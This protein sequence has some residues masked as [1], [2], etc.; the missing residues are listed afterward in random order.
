M[1]DYTTAGRSSHTPSSRASAETPPSSTVTKAKGEGQIIRE[2]FRSSLEQLAQVQTRLAQENSNHEMRADAIM[3]DLDG[4]R[5]GLREIQAE[6]RQNQGR[7]EASV[8]FLNDLIKQRETVADTRMAEMSAI[9][10]ERDRQ[11]DERMKLMAD[12]MQRRDI[13]ANVR[14]VD[15]MTTMQD[16]TL[17]V[18]AIVS[19]TAATQEQAAPRAPPN[20]Q[21]ADM[22]S[23]SAA[24]QAPYRTVAKSTAEQ[25]RPPK[26]APPAT[27]KRDPPK[28]TKMAKIV[29]PESRDAGT[30]PMSDLSSFDLYAR[31][32][33]TSGGSHSAADETR[34]TSYYT[35]NSSAAFP[36]PARTQTFKDFV[37]RPV[38][39]STQRKLTTKRN[40]DQDHDDAE[41]LPVVAEETPDNPRTSQR[42]ALAEALSTAMSKGLEPLLAVKES[43]NKP[44]KYTGT[45]DRTADGWMMLIKRHLEKAHAEATPLDKAWT[46]IEYMEHEARDYI[47][48]KSEAERD[49]DEKVFALLARRFG[50]GSS[51]IHIQQQFRTRNQNSEKDYMQYL[52][53]LEG[54]RSQRYPNEEVTVRRYEIM[55]RFI[56]AVRNFELKRNLALIFAPEQYVEAPPTVEA[57]RFTVQQNLRMRGSSRSF[58]YP[59]AP[60]QHQQA[61]HPQPNHSPAAPPP[62][63]NCNNS[64]HHN[65]PPTINN[66]NR[67]RPTDSNPRGRASTVAIHH[68]LL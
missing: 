20:Y 11:A 62:A 24:P 38:K 47:T 18:K 29:H 7:L 28:L 32:V 51:T 55:Q 40:L 26:L 45:R 48:N 50:T 9:M 31:G 15:L 67:E 17:G 1:I 6:G 19:Q 58:N 66:L 8:E 14:M 5:K 52:D 41:E 60:P 68:T 33:S 65:L 25:V 35:A 57:L 53:A 36:L 54:L 34:R 49:T 23:T 21:Q 4:M 46:I 56:E 3:R 27:Y 10:K 30:D 43:K 61:N 37:P 59:M 22:P 2:D 63:Q 64:H 16:L 44:T 39:T 12:T 42:Q 13:D